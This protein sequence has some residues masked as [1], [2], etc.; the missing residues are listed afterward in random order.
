MLSGMLQYQ[1]FSSV[2]PTNEEE[3]SHMPK[4]SALQTSA[5]NRGIKATLGRQ[6]DESSYLSR[7]RNLKVQLDHK[8]KRKRPSHAMRHLNL[9]QKLAKNF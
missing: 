3:E 8:G 4:C 2:A 5:E 9:S 6:S 1:V 7:N